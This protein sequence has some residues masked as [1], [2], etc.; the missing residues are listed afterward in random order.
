MSTRSSNASSGP[1]IESIAGAAI[2]AH[3]FVVA[4]D[5][6]WRI[7]HTSDNLHE[8]LNDEGA[9]ITGR[10]LS[11]LF[12]SAVVH[13]LRNQLSLSRDPE[14]GARLFAVDLPGSSRPFDMAMRMRD[15][16]VSMDVL[17]A[18]HV[19]AGDPIG[20][21]R[22]LFTSLND[23]SIADTKLRACALM[24]ALTGFGMVAMIGA[25]GEVAC[26]SSRSEGDAPPPPPFPT[27][28]TRLICD[29][30]GVTSALPPGADAAC[31]ETSLLREAESTERNWMRQC[32]AV[33]CMRLPATVPG[34]VLCEFVGL[35]RSRRLMPLDR[36]A[37]AELFTD[38]IGMRI[39][40][41]EAQMQT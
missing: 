41:M 19:E 15:D 11:D 17:P 32:G 37:A 20:S 14:R 28:Q 4:V 34:G 6:D 12:S 33:A 25:D 18:A 2:Q 36:V 21:V 39:A 8:F 38:M 13:A 40:L 9:A 24:R 16:R 35:D 3:G 31:I 29:L 30:D 7:L 5:R 26:V 10:P 27:A 23:M 1:E 22:D